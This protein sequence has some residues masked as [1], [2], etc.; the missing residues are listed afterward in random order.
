MTASLRKKLNMHWARCV[1]DKRL[2]LQLLRVTPFIFTA[3][4]SS[5]D[6]LLNYDLEEPFAILS[7][8]SSQNPRIY[9]GSLWIS[10]KFISYVHDPL[11]KCSRR[12]RVAE[13][14][15]WLIRILG[16]SIQYLEKEKE[17][18][19]FIESFSIIQEFHTDALVF[20]QMIGVTKAIN[21][22]NKSRVRPQL[23][24]QVKTISKKKCGGVRKNKCDCPKPC[25]NITPTVDL[26]PPKQSYR[27]SFVVG[28]LPGVFAVEKPTDYITTSPL[29]FT[30]N[31]ENIP[32]TDVPTEYSTSPFSKDSSLFKD[33]FDSNDDSLIGLINLSNIA[34]NEI[35]TSNV[36]VSRNASTNITLSVV[37]SESELRPS[38]TQYFSLRNADS[39]NPETFGTSAVEINSSVQITNSVLESTYGSFSD[40]DL[41]DHSVSSSGEQNAIGGCIDVPAF[42]KQPSVGSV[43][44][45]LTQFFQ[46]IKEKFSPKGSWV[47]PLIDRI[48]R[49]IS[50]D[51]P[52]AKR[53][54][55]SPSTESPTFLMPSSVASSPILSS[56]S[57]TNWSTSYNNLEFSSYTFDKSQS[58]SSARVS[59]PRSLPVVCYKRQRGNLLHEIAS[60]SGNATSNNSNS[61]GSPC[62][63]LTNSRRISFSKQ[64]K[65]ILKNHINSINEIC[66][67]PVNH[68]NVLELR[69]RFN[70]LSDL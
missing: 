62:C 2:A 24:V 46:R 60:F 63:S 21:I 41:P 31:K 23:A 61:I 18:F 44:E 30:E 36:E 68:K 40:I 50:E 34:T 8:S 70:M 53:P 67:I 25:L 65:R 20:S 3:S 16:F 7:T 45:S 4:R 57:L 58:Y 32:L 38:S 59:T 26:S 17:H 33:L 55:Q 51:E 48:L 47:T 27:T 49:P 12:I 29:T 35:L 14:C 10:V 56:A 52:S 54:L 22:T 13:K 42:S 11:P 37:P 69:K 5:P 1:P 15:F 64:E 9:D 28:S 66:R 19:A 43:R 39:L 6:R